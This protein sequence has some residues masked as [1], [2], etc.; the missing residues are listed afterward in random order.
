MHKIVVKNTCIIINDY[1]FNSNPQLENY[2]R[3][4]DPVT[5]GYYYVGIYY[6]KEN[7]RL[8]LPRGIDIYFVEKIFNAVA[9][10]EKNQYYPYDTSNRILIKYMPKDDVQKQALRFM[11][12]EGEYRDTKYKSQLHVNLNTGK[13][14]T[15]VSI[16][17][18]A[19]TG[20][21]GMIITYSVDI[22]RQWSDRVQEYC[23]IKPSEIYIINGDG[24]GSIKNLLNRTPDQLSKYKL[25]LV[26]HSTLKTYGDTNGWD[27][28]GELFKYLRIGIKIF[29]E[30]HQN[31]TNTCM[32]DFY[33]NV[34]KTYYLTAT[35][36]RSNADENR[37]YQLAFKNVL[38]IDLFDKENDPHTDYVSF[39]YNSHPEPQVISR[40]KNQYGLDRNKYVNY[41]TVQEKFKQAFVILMEI[42]L[43]DIMYGDK[44]LIYIGTNEGIYNVYN[45]FI[46]IFPEWAHYTGIYSSVV[47]NEEKLI[48]LSKSIIFTTTKSA[49]AALDLP[50]LKYTILLAEPFKSE[51]LTQQTLG[52]TRAAN[53]FYFELVDKG[54]YHCK[55]FYRYKKPIFAKYA[56]TCT[57]IDINDNELESRF[58]R[59]IEKRQKLTYPIK[60]N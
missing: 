5:H 3:I 33:T 14:K 21:K 42:V 28:I 11:L 46:E 40:C 1:E 13:G 24:Y 8:F 17:A 47:S 36:G 44:C 30:A 59:I 35:P 20:I 41:I 10:V 58:N 38:A 55:K 49:G 9:Y 19:Y 6:D 37:I 18:L 32:I 31:F 53:T 52:R 54:F 15:Y 27:K 60:Y 29:D 2:F 4:Y 50:G 51:V 56:K 45:Y 43:P 23:N 34:Y 22:L 16:A 48:A 7:K 39:I 12:G 26:T 57:E 25:F